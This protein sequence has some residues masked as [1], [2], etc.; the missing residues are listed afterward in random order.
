[1]IQNSGT[2]FRPAYPVHETR[3]GWR[4]L[5][6]PERLLLDPMADCPQ[7]QTLGQ[8]LAPRANGKQLKIL[9]DR[10]SLTFPCRGFD[11]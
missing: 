2:G 3:K 8:Q 10:I 4:T 9:S 7:A 5:S 11:M 1:M 6:L